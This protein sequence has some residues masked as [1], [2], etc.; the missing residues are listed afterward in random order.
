MTV[1]HGM[2]TA[3]GLTAGAQLE[4]GSQEIVRIA[5]SV[6]QALYAFD[7][8]GT[9]ADDT[10]STWD[11]TY[12]PDLDAVAAAVAEIARL[13]KAEAQAQD[14]ASG[15]AATTAGAGALG[16]SGAPAGA[17]DPQTQRL[18]DRARASG[19]SG[20]ALNRYTQQLAAMTPAER[21]ALDPANF[22]GPQAVQPDG[23][24][25]GSSSLVMSRMI[26]NPAYAMQVIT[27]YD[28]T[29]GQTTGGTAQDR[30]AAEALA[31]H[32]R[33]NAWHDRDGHLQPAWPMG[34]G[35]A[36]GPLANEMSAPGGS[37]V[38]G[39]QYDVDYVRWEN[40][41]SSYDKMLAATQAGHTVPVYVGNNIHPGHIVLV[42]GADANGNLTFYEPGGGQ[43]VT[44]S[45]QQWESGQ[46][47][48]GGWDK[49]WAIVTPRN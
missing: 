37:G 24:T 4:S 40:P 33:T 17:P 10:R 28:P 48:L 16:F 39:T 44:V 3:A 46:I 42:T 13:I 38:P 7:W 31:M 5:T 34:L 45:R 41:G 1:T 9:D 21:A 47:S 27:G 8:Y 49:P 36:P 15:E 20:D 35:T 32:E 43:T 14:E 29:T 18:I 25:C 12:R 19:L 2:D 30:F 22:R 26:N 6:G 23:T 11:G